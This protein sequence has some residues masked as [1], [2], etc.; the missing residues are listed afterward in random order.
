MSPPKVRALHYYIIILRK[1]DFDHL[2]KKQITLTHTLNL[3]IFKFVSNN[4]R[5]KFEYRIIRNNLT[6]IEKIFAWFN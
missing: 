6:H 3:Y 4:L 5:S 1:N 2:K